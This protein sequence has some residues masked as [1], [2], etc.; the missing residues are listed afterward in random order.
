[1]A[2]LPPMPPVDRPTAPLTERLEPGRA[3]FDRGEFFEAH[4][5]WEEVWRALAGEER[6]LAQGL[7][8]LAAGLH[9]LLRGRSRPAA[10]LVAKGVEKISRC[11]PGL[12]R[13]V[14]VDSLVRAAVRR[15]TE[16]E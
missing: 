14:R 16:V 13:E 6:L 12:R 3:A 9:H 2:G 8:Q 15:L 11:A 4:E 1:M 7:I 5:L 10:R